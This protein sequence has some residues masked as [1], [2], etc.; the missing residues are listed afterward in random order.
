MR[1]ATI[2]LGRSGGIWGLTH[3]YCLMIGASQSAFQH[4]EPIFRTLTLPEH[5]SGC[6]VRQSLAVP[7]EF[8]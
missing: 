1:P 2:G 3:G 6:K 8:R 5:H 4:S 7:I